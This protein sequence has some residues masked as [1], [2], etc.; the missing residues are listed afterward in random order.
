[1][2]D[3]E[4]AKILVIGDG[5]VPTG[6]SRVIHSM[7]KNIPKDGYEF[8]HLAVNYSGDPHEFD[9][10][11]YP[12]RLAGIPTN[13]LG[14]DRIPQMLNQIKPEIIFILNDIWIIKEY[15]KVIRNVYNYKTVPKIVVYFPVDG[16]GYRKEWFDDFDVV[17]KTCVY[18][19]FGKEQVKSVYP[20][21]EVEI[22][23]HG[24]DI[25]DFYPLNEDRQEYKK[26]FYKGNKTI[27]PESFIV[28]NANRNQPRKML[29]VSIYGFALFARD[30]DDVRYHHHAGLQD[31]GW[32]IISL[33]EIFSKELGYDVSKKLILSNQ[34]E[35][36][37]TVS[38]GK[39]NEYYNASD[40]G[41]NT[42][43]GEGWGLVSMEHAVTGA[44]Q[45]VPNHSA[46]TE[47]YS[48]CAIMLE[49]KMTFRGYE[50]LLKRKYVAAE[51]VANALNSL[52]TNKELYDEIAK[53]AYDKF[54]S[55]KYSWKNIAKLWDNI[56]KEI[57]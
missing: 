45:I 50:T 7:I 6:F 51:D 44:P 24:I 12:A 3:K 43:T 2:T 55:P 47:I 4:K 21:L 56:F 8:H 35:G 20:G 32:D 36:V 16:E 30:K 48:D 26:E 10:K 1:M 19:E 41:L 15:L 22:I 5:V 42:S 46:C 18:T 9:H 57:L 37:Q 27:N 17:S 28:L 52:Y 31:S 11:I 40:V 54:T 33:A 39:L 25:E 13:P 53:K 49:P 23:P 34:Q 29:D 14:F 38:D